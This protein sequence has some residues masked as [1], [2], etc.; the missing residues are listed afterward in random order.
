MN[1]FLV[2]CEIGKSVTVY[3]VEGVDET[4]LT[5]LKDIDDH[6]SNSGF[7]LEIAEMHKLIVHQMEWERAKVTKVS[8][9]ALCKVI[10]HVI[11]TGIGE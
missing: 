6:F 10:H 11:V 5:R 9:T 1:V 2:W 8:E 3:L 7:I 4:L